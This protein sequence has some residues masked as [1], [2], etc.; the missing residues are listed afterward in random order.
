ML[1]VAIVEC[2]DEYM[3]TLKPC[4]FCGEPQGYTVDNYGWCTTTHECD[5]IEK[6]SFPSYDDMVNSWNER[7]NG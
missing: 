3:E 1:S 6:V 2:G 5:F 4:P 7:S